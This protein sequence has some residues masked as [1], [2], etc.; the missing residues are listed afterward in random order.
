VPPTQP[1]GQLLRVAAHLGTKLLQGQAANL[2]V[3][4]EA[5]HYIVR[6][7]N[8]IVPEEGNDLG[9]EPEID[10]PSVLPVP[11]GGSGHADLDRDIFLVQPEFDTASA[12]VVA[13]GVGFLIELWKW[14]KL[15]RNLDF[16]GRFYLLEILGKEV[17]IPGVLCIFSTTLKEGK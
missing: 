4:S 5:F 17:H 16:V 6:I 3:P 1:V 13:E 9:D 7:G 15:K 2:L 10:D 8:G 11:D 14:R 12:Q